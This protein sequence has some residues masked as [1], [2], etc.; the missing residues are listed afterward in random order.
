MGAVGWCR[1]GCCR[2][3]CW[4][5]SG[6]VGRYAGW[7]RPATRAT[8]HKYQ[9]LVKRSFLKP[10]LPGYW[11]HAPESTL[12]PP[13]RLPPKPQNPAGRE[14]PFRRPTPRGGFGSGGGAK[15]SVRR[16]G[17]ARAAPRG[18]RS[19]CARAARPARRQLPAQRRLTPGAQ[20]RQ[21]TIPRPTGVPRRAT[22]PV[23]IDPAR[24]HAMLRHT[25][26]TKSAVFSGPSRV[27]IPKRLRRKK[28]P[29]PKYSGGQPK[30]PA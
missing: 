15:G 25:S 19:G 18:A 27:V 5:L 14:A 13:R 20:V 16:V 4:G 10:S 22:L 17:P 23:Q 21:T 30:W 1:V 8:R 2:H 12:Q 29:R 11:R 28:K 26:P 7:G 6:P 9:V 24:P 3:G